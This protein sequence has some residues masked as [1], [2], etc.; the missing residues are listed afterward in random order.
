MLTADWE[1][2]ATYLFKEGLLPVG[3][4]FFIESSG[5]WTWNK[6]ECTIYAHPFWEGAKG[7]VFQEFVENPQYRDNDDEFLVNK[8]I[9]FY[10]TGDEQKDTDEYLRLINEELM[11][12][13]SPCYMSGMGSTSLSVDMFNYNVCKYLEENPRYIDSCE[14][15]GKEFKFYIE[16]VHGEKLKI[17]Q[18]SRNSH[19]NFYKIYSAEHPDRLVKFE[20][21]PY[22]GF[23]GLMKEW[24]ES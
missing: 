20:I 1:A 7:I 22:D 10:L 17:I 2:V 8:I 18:R 9:P 13:E 24:G 21:N 5:C 4:Q 14:L 3:W 12:L 6:E 23:V 16:A 11:L 19:S 15:G